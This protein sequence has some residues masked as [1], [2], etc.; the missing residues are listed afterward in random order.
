MYKPWIPHFGNKTPYTT[1]AQDR[2]TRAE[3]ELKEA[4]K[5]EEED[6]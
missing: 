6:S 2:V 3:E 4:I 5:A 1:G